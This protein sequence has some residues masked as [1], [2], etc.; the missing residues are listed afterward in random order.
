MSVSEENKSHGL[1]DLAHRGLIDLEQSNSEIRHWIITD[2][3]NF[4]LET[5]HS[6]NEAGVSNVLVTN[7]DDTIK[8]LT[9]KIIATL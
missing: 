2:D 5:K 7:A 1:F 3:K 4:R 8:D 9:E 6:P